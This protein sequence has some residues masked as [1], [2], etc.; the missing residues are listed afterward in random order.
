VLLAVALPFTR[1]AGLLGFVPLPGIFLGA[2]ACVVVAY[3]AL[4]QIAKRI[5]VPRTAMDT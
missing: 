4:V 3:L 5:L 1:V 2:L